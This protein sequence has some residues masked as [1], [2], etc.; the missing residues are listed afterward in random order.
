[1]AAH[2]N[3]RDLGPLRPA[4]RRSAVWW[5]VLGK[6]L[7][8]YPDFQRITGGHGPGLVQGL[9]AAPPSTR[10]S[11]SEKKIAGYMKP[12]SLLL[13]FEMPRSAVRAPCGGSAETGAG[14]VRRLLVPILLN[15]GFGYENL[16]LYSPLAVD[17]RL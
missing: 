11:S 6:T 8:P 9:G 2:Q 15:G 13:V 5:A 1:M 4:G 12:G 14:G 16:R 17:D 7:Q 10:Y 3:H